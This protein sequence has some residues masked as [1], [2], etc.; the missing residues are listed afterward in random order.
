MGTC[1]CLTSQ[2]VAESVIDRVEDVREEFRSEA[3]FCEER[4]AGERFADCIHCYYILLYPSDDIFV[5]FLLQPVCGIFSTM[6]IKD[7][8]K[9]QR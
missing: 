2:L 1:C 9:S 5:Q 7:N 4:L 6:A 3:G 8:C